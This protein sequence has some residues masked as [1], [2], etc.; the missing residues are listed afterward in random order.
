MPRLTWGISLVQVKAIRVSDIVLREASFMAPGR[1]PGSDEEVRPERSPVPR[2]AVRRA[3]DSAMAGPAAEAA[4]GSILLSHGKNDLTANVAA[5][6][7]A[8]PSVRC[9][10]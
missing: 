7:L 1:A 4:F 2:G 3:A 8:W 10:V 5:A 9:G 6:S